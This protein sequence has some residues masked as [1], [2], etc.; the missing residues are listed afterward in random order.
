MDE[1]GFVDGTFNTHFLKLSAAEQETNLA[2]A[3]AIPFADTNVKLKEYQFAKEEESQ[4]STWQLLMALKDCELQNDALLDVLY[5]L[6]GEKY[7]AYYDYAV[8]FFYGTYDIPL[9]GSDKENQWESE[10][11]YQFMI[12]TVAPLQG[13]YEPGKPQC[14]FMFPAF[15]DRSANIHAVD[16]F[17]KDDTMPHMEL[18]TDILGINELK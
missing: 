4:G 2:L 15:A 16:I 13:E 3:K 6:F 9:K 14:G 7:Q 18:V 5:D 10:E 1:E 12:C 8:F 17:Q 11:V